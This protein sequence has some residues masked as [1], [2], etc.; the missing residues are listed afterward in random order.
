MLKAA[1]DHGKEFLALGFS[2]SHVVHSCGSMCQAITELATRKNANIQ[3]YEFSILN[4]CLDVAI[5]A[6]V[7]EYQFRSSEFI[8][9]K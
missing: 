2:L 4:G 3:A 1:A 8:K 7:S 9:K 6:F 5:A